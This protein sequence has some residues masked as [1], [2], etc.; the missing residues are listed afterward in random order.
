MLIAGKGKALIFLW[1][2][3]TVMSLL[4]VKTESTSYMINS[5]P[6]RLRLSLATQSV[7]FDSQQVYSPPTTRLLQSTLGVP[8]LARW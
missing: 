6:S 8:K 7:L 4:W 5:Q 2:G 1:S 3:G